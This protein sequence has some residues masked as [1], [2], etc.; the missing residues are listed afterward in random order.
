VSAVVSAGRAA[1]RSDDRRIKATC[2]VVERG[3][4][5]V[6]RTPAVAE[7]DS[8]WFTDRGFCVVQTLLMLRRDTVPRT[9]RETDETA[10][11]SWRRLRARR[12][13]EL[14]ES[15]LQLDATA[16]AP[17]WN[18]SLEAFARA[19]RA[20]S[21]HAVL[22]TDTDPPTAYALVGRSAQTA[23][24]QRLAVRPERRREGIARRLVQDG[25]AW[26]HARGAIELLVNT[27]P[28]NDA[29]LALYRGL[30]FVTMPE[31]L[32]VLEREIH[33]CA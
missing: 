6:H 21:E 13:D 3:T 15:L 22:V 30:G 25:L 1:R 4:A 23:Y 20:T 28:G 10:L 11:W 27:E 2:A 9:S 18:L 29:A 16:F 31:R 14:R 33:Q 26:A 24:L 8:R 32:H 5:L 7:H 17:P 12:N 19:C